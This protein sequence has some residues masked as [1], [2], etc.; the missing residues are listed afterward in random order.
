MRELGV[1][2]SRAESIRKPVKKLG[3]VEHLQACYEAGPAGYVLYWQLTELGVDC[4]VIA[5][6]LARCHRAG[7]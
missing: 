2:A 5:P 4:E 1:I 6:K 7:I 3:P